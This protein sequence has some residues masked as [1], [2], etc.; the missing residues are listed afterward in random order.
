MLG[1]AV[2]GRM[3]STTMPAVGRTYHENLHWWRYV[4]TIP[5]PRVMVVEDADENPGA[6]ALVGEMHAVIGMALK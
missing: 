5:E 4:E 3:R 6:G 1:Y 2:T